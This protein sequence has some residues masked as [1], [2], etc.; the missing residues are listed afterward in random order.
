[1]TGED[2]DIH[3]WNIRTRRLVKKLNGHFDWIRRVTFSPDG[4]VLASAG[5]D[6]RILFW[7]TQSWNQMFEAA[8]HQ[9]AFMKTAF[10]TP[11]KYLATT[12]FEPDFRIYDTVSD[13]LLF[14]LIYPSEDMRTVAFLPME[15]AL[16]P[17]FAMGLCE[18]GIFPLASNCTTFGHIDKESD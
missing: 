14:R 15:V 5:N 3:T 9:Q 17:A 18:F 4:R 16:P 10:D 8:R 1:M 11:G 7:D 2:H 6:R 12:G 13:Q